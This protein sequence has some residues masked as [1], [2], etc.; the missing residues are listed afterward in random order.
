MLF[1]CSSKI[2]LHKC[3]IFGDFKWK[4]QQFCDIWKINEIIIRWPCCPHYGWC[5]VITLALVYITGPT[6]HNLDE[7][8]YSIASP[9]IGCKQN[10]LQQI[11][12]ACVSLYLVCA[13]TSRIKQLV[14]CACQ[15][16]L[17]WSSWYEN[18]LTMRWT[19]ESVCQW[20]A[21]E[22]LIEAKV[23]KFF[24]FF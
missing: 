10:G 21:S 20:H 4:W 3:R 24:D 8:V 14:L 16:P 13:C 12:W 1:S 19:M 23:A 22:Y 15:L 5:W 6:C 9:A 18:N 11:F 17:C 2:S 7:Q